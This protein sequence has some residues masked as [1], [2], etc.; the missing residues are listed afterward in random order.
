M[1]NNVLKQ[2]LHDHK[3]KS[4]GQKARDQVQEDIFLATLKNGKTYADE[5][6]LFV[7]ILL[8]LLTAFVVYLGFN[9]YLDTF[10]EMFPEWAAIAFAICLPLGVELAKI[11]LSMLG[12]RSLLFGWLVSSWPSVAFWLLVIGLAI[13]GFVWSYSISTGGIK[14]VAREKSEVKNELP[15]LE[16]VI[17]LACVDIDAQ[18]AA[19]TTSNTEASTMK[20]KKGKIAWSGQVI[21]MNNSEALPSLLKQRADL[22][23]DKAAWYHNQEGKVETKV[24]RWAGFIERFGGWGEWGTLFCVLAIGFFELRLREANKTSPDDPSPENTSKGATVQILTN[25]KTATFADNAQSNPLP[26]GQIGFVWDGYGTPPINAVTTV[27]QSPRPVTQPAQINPT[28]L[29]SNQILLQLRTKLQAD[30]PNFHKNN[31]IP[32]T[33]SARINKAFN[34]C[35]EAMNHQDFK[36]TRDIGAAVYGYLVETAIPTINGLGYPYERDKQFLKRLMDVIPKEHA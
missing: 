31:G 14:E 18:I 16:K 6:I 20:T 33:I 25:G 1:S 29:G 22:A 2:L 10:R 34:E 24:N 8:I 12:L 27:S 11:K 28:V 26:K 17:S 30:I 9:Y 3:Q 7:R 13:G 23:A 4:E 15:P 36:P 19:I 21:Q 35:F 32:A 5:A